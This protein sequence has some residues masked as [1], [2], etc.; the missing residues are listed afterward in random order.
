M[1]WK[2]E[3]LD[4]LFAPESIAI[5]GASEKS[6]KLGSL[7]L[8]ALR[9]Y[10]CKKYPVNPRHTEIGGMECF[11]SVVDIG[12]E[13][14]LAVIALGPRQVL[15]ALSNC[16]KAG[17]RAAIIFSA[18]FRELGPLGEEHQEAVKSVADEAHIAV[19]GPN[20][21]GAGNVGRGLNATFFPHPVPLG[22]GSVS[23]VSQSGGV[24]GLMIY[25][26][27]DADLGVAK[28]ASVGNRVN[29]D[30]PDMLRYLQQ[31][32]ETKVICLF[33]E[34]TE[35]ARE[36]YEE[37][38]KTT[39]TKPVIVYKVGTTPVAQQAAMSH[40]GSLAGR[41]ELYSAAVRQAGAIE[42]DTVS[43]MID[44]A[45]ILG[46][47]KKRPTN[48]RVAIVTHTLGPALIAAQIL[49]TRGAQLPPPADETS[50]AVQ[51]MLGMPVEINITNPIDLLA[52][53]W[54]RP[55]IFAGAYELIIKEPQYDSVIIMFSPNYQEEIGGGMPVEAIVQATSKSDKT[56][57]AVLNAPE[58]RP[59][60]GRGILEEGGIPV[61]SSP[62]RAACALANTLKPVKTS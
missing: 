40:T 29:I 52:Q 19:I 9:D 8:L 42:V 24:T 44:T 16:A 3:S 33:V 26:A 7:T 54:A 2:I 30:F 36:M 56:V 1:D 53:G 13:I 18:G 20:C 48:R 14:D 25:A 60:F 27:S 46:F 28:Y 6:D 11:P 34:G 35:R 5:V 31:D 15:S 50:A 21:L 39:Q 12:E 22:G 59:P 38:G 10:Q 23:F 32:K 58:C 43:E 47:S 37:M 4:R 57:V 55:D 51:D 62:E 17:V 41:H 49:E 61:F 45:K